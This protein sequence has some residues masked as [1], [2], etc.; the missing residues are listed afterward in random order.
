[1]SKMVANT[2]KLFSAAILGQLLGLIAMPI[3]SRL[4][5]PADFGIYQLFFSIVAVI[6]V[7]SRFSYDY[8]INIPEKHE[9]AANIIVLCIFLIIITSIATMIFFFIFSGYIDSL[10]KTPGFSQYLFLLPLAI[11]CN[12]FAYILGLWLSRKEEFGII[13]KANL[14]SSISGKAVSLGTGFISPSPAG[15]IFGVIVN[16]A[17]IFIIFLKQILADIQF[18]KDVSYNRI[19]QLAIRYKKFPQYTLSAEFVGTASYQCIP[20]LLAF[21]FSSIIVGYYAMSIIMI[22]LPLKLIANSFSS[23]FYQKLNVEKNL[24]GNINKIVKSVHT[25]LISIGMFGCLIGIIIGP[26][27]FAFILGEKW[28][29]AG[30]YAQILMP[31]FFVM[32]ISIPLLTIINVTEKQEISFLFYLYSF[33]STVF[34]LIIGGYYG[35]PYVVMLLLS[36]NGVVSWGWMNLYTLKIAGVSRRDAASE[37]IRYFIF[38]LCISLPLL[39]VKYLAFQSIVLILIAIVVSVIYYLIILNQDTQLKNGLIDFISGIRQK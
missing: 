36:F 27:L 29:T 14:A 28:Y 39:I 38:G 15:L 3:L 12:S 10:F 30:V 23:V 34:I 33:I 31:S 6:A 8:A 13:A 32:F 35:N 21:F 37:I 24:S 17:T 2:L 7:I 25:R 1:M 19:K 26:E 4:Y 22:N 5:T 11:I 16:D 9:D 20:F 18:F